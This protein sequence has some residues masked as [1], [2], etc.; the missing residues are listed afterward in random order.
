MLIS[1]LCV[2]NPTLARKLPVGWKSC[3]SANTFRTWDIDAKIVSL[4]P[5]KINLSV[6]IYSDLMLYGTVMQFKLDFTVNCNVIIN[7]YRHLKGELLMGIL[8]HLLL[9][10]SYSVFLRLWFILSLDN[11]L[12]TGITIFI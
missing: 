9:K 4:Q 6:F 11:G 12:I 8:W 2:G 7:V 5:C 1:V 10:Y 3:S